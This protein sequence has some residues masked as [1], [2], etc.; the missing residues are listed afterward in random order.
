MLPS[1]QKGT[2]IMPE[3]SIILPTYNRADVIG[4]A[5]VS[6]LRQSMPDWELIVVD[7]GSTD[8]T[9]ER[10]AGLDG[11]IRLLRQDNQGVYVARNTGL[12]AARAELITFL[13]SDDEWLPHFLE[14]TTGF[15]RAHPQR[16]WVST[17]FLEDLGDG[18]PPV[19]HDRDDIAQIYCRFA[20]SIGSRELDL[21][22]GLDDDYLRVYS[23]R[24]QA[25]AWARGALD[26]A[27]QSQ[28]WVYEGDIFRAMRWGYLNW[29]PVTVLRRSALEAIGPF[30]TATRSAADYHFL[31]RLARHS[32]ASMIALPGAVK[33]ERA[34]GNRRLAQ[35]H[36]ATG[37]GAWRFELNKLRYFD[38]LHVMPAPQD[39]STALLRRHYCLSAA[40]RGIA[41]GQRR[42][43]IA[44]L[45]QAAA[46]RPRLWTAWPVLALAHALPGDRLCA[47]VWNRSRRVVDVL[48]R[49]LGGR[50]SPRRLLQ[51]LLLRLPGRGRDL[52]VA[53]E[54]GPD[55]TE[56]AL[57]DWRRQPQPAARPP[58]RHETKHDDT[59]AK[60]RRS[61]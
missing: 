12:A 57:A 48:G 36:L 10:L 24:L 9:L 16:D 25:G 46:P 17:E 2:P 61:I 26:A 13:D 4:R 40:L 30:T 50:L 5:V 29:L 60:G 49:L 23:R 56:Q 37:A 53:D 20:R 47:G 19:R 15:L 52:A 32:E 43:A 54:A 11:R 22:T 44:L 38:E 51:R 59:W 42:E 58:E 34:A 1:H 7:D 39:A 33:H 27:G 45:R 35:D 6:V 3:V 28:A 8:G 41:A 18:A 55:L 21:P 31:A 14:M